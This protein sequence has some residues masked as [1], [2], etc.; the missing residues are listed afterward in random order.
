MTDANKRNSSLDALDKNVCKK[1]L[2]KQCAI[3]SQAEVRIW[4]A[5]AHSAINKLKILFQVVSKYKREMS[6]VIQGKGFSWWATW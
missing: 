4:R 5:N 2:Q 6:Y 1:E 3:G